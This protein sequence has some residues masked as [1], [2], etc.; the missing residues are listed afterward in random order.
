[1]KRNLDGIYIRVQEVDGSW[2]SKCLSDCT[3][4]QRKE[5]MD[6]HGIDQY[7]Q[8]VIQHLAGTLRYIGDLADVSVTAP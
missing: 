7:A 5:W 1:M 6:S 4:E 3:T 8:E 2:G